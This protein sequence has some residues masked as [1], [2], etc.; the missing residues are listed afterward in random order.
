M[1]RTKTFV[2]AAALF[3]AGVACGGAGA[4]IVVG[5]RSGPALAF[6]HGR[7]D[8]GIHMATRRLARTLRL[9]PSQREVLADVAASTASRIAAIQ[10]ESFPRVE[11][12]LRDG[13][14]RLAPSLRPD[15]L[16]RL[17]GILDEALARRRAGRARLPPAR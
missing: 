17:D 3:V 7:P 6:L 1:T 10:D 15:Q 9:D 11:Q 13:R 2:L 14:D 16:E 4:L 5:A 12:A 8:V